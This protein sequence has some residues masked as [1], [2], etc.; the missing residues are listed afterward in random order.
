MEVQ[1]FGYLLKHPGHDHGS[2]D[3][4][5]DHDHPKGSTLVP[6]LITM[7]IL[8][9]LSFFCSTFPLLVKLNQ[10]RKT[11]KSEEERIR[12]KNIEERIVSLLMS[13][14]GGVLFCTIFIHVLP[15]VEEIFEKHLKTI[16][17]HELEILPQL[18]MCAGFFMMYIIEE[19]THYTM[20]NC[21]C[22]G[23]G[24]KHTHNSTPNLKARDDYYR[25][26]SDS[27]IVQEIMDKLD[28]NA[29]NLTFDQ[30]QKIIDSVRRAIHVN[31][32][33][34]KTKEVDQLAV[35]IPVRES[36]VNSSDVCH[37]HS[38]GHHDHS[39]LPLTGSSAMRSFLFALALSIH[40]LFEGLSIGLQDTT[41]AV[42]YMVI[43]VGAHKLVLAFCMG[44]EMVAGEVKLSLYIAYSLMFAAVSPIGIACGITLSTGEGITAAVFQGLA[45]GTL[46]YVLFFEILQRKSHV[47]G[48]I[49][50]I[51]VICGFLIMFGLHFI[52]LE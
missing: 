46:V 7:L 51:F 26:S 37:S 33:E 16:D 45:C 34:Y 4:D 3:H 25:P 1:M 42:W 2:E 23:G 35:T 29:T 14:A 21:G 32:V 52:E 8:G 48:L 31:A 43:G 27:K 44:V 40:E 12:A 30:R 28:E 11:Y 10:K 39:H 41:S 6:K 17:I 9:G 15:E 20:H 5:H 22:N 38:Q 13:F 47:S 19:V 50:C 49:S 24:D 18:L 36:D